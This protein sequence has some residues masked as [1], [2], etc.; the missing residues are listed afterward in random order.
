M[1][2]TMSRDE[3]SVVRRGGQEC[4]AGIKVL[5]IPGPLHRHC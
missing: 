4:G 3:D 1:E 2:G 5:R